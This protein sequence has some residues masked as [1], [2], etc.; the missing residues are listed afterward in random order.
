[1]PWAKLVIDRFHVARA[2]RDCADTVR[3]QELKPLG[4]T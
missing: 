4:H 1:V 3:T 2:Y